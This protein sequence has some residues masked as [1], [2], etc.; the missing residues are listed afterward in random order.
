MTDWADELAKEVIAVSQG[1]LFLAKM[2]RK[3]KADGYRQ[4]AWEFEE[5]SNHNGPLIEANAK[6][7]EDGTFEIEGKTDGQQ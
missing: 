6:K 4:G 3:A 2:L 5:D 1:Q 7:I